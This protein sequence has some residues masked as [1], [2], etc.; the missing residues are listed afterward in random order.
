LI[1][2]LTADVLRSMP[3]PQPGVHADKDER[4]RVLVVGSSLAV[5]GAVLL[6]GIAALRAGAGKLQIAV[7]AP[8]AV[9]IGIACP[10]TAVIPLG[11]DEAGHPFSRVDGHLCKSALDADGILVGPGLMDAVG[12]KN[13]LSNL[14]ATTTD[15]GFVVDAAALAQILSLED[16]VREKEGRLVL[17]PHSGEMAT[18]LGRPK[19]TI[20]ADPQGAAREVATKLRCVVALKGATTFVCDPH[21]NMWRNDGGA[22]GLG[23]CGSGDVLAGI[24]TGLIARGAMPLE[25]TLWGVFVHARIGERLSEKIGTLGFLARELLPEIPATLEEV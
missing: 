11:Q 4:G 12:A 22:V 24:M 19:A 8:L 20:E 5:P 2:E 14:L 16:L 10:E 9:A 23:T 13:L 6:S 1:E 21:G 3:L 17:T 25:A 7:P 15:A 18:L